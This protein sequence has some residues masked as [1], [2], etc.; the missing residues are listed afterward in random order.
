M[1]L[2][3]AMQVVGGMP[4]LLPRKNLPKRRRGETPESQP[5]PTLTMF[6]RSEQIRPRAVQAE[7]AKA[8]GVL[9]GG[10]EVTTERR[11]G[12]V[13]YLP[14]RLGARPRQ[15]EGEVSA[16]KQGLAI[17]LNIL[18]SDATRALAPR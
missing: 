2:E 18:V 8:A 7:E 10:T 12:P 16:R 17:A 1:R 15:S 5:P 3:D 4:I 6:G 11:R 14:A 13:H 9:S